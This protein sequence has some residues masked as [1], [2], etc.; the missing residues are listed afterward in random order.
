[1]ASIF[2]TIKQAEEILDEV[3]RVVRNEQQSPHPAL[4]EVDQSKVEEE[5]Q[6]YDEIYHM[7]IKHNANYKDPFTVSGVVSK[8]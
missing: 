1:M 3:L 4:S 7:T 5:V 2:D 8:R 6:R